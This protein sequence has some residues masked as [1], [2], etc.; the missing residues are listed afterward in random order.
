MIWVSVAGYFAI[1][2]FAAWL[3]ITRR[4]RSPVVFFWLGGISVLPFMLVLIARF[5]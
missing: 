5:I 4:A 3:D 1:A 2:L